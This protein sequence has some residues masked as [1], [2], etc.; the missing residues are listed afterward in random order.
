MFEIISIQIMCA[1]FAMVY[2][3]ADFLSWQNSLA[4]SL[5]IL[6]DNFSLLSLAAWLKISTKLLFAGSKCHVAIR[7]Q[8]QLKFFKMAERSNGCSGKI[9][10]APVQGRKRCREK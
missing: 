6:V 4:Y 3:K 2:V 8:W 7:R 1:S 5:P 9:L 10:L